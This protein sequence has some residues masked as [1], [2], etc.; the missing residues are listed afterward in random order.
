MLLGYGMLSADVKPPFTIN[1]VS[2]PGTINGQAVNLFVRCFYVKLN[3]FIPS[4]GYGM[5]SADVKP[6]FTINPVSDPGT[7]NGQAVNLFV[8]CFYV[9]LNTFIPSVYNKN[10]S[11]VCEFN[12]RRV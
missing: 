6:P 2:D 7:I 8:R 5:L 9:K 10:I 1:P 11:F 4:V 3:T 12:F